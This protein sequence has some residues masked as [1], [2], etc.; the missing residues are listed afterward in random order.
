[1]LLILSVEGP[2]WLPL[3]N[4]SLVGQNEYWGWG[5]SS[6]AVSTPGKG[7][8]EPLGAHGGARGGLWGLDDWD[9]ITGCP[10]ADKPR[11]GGLVGGWARLTRS[12]PDELDLLSDSWIWWSLNGAR[13]GCADFISFAGN[14]V[15]LNFTS[16][17]ISKHWW[18]AYQ[19]WYP[20]DPGSYPTKI[21]SQLLGSSLCLLFLKCAPKLDN[22]R[23]IGVRCSAFFWTE[24]L[25]VFYSLLILLVLYVWSLAL[26]DWPWSG[27]VW[28]WALFSW[29]WTCISEFSPGGWWT[30]N[31][32][33]PNWVCIGKLF[34]YI[35]Q[36][37]FMV[38]HHDRTKYGSIS[39]YIFSSSHQ[40]ALSSHFHS[41]PTWKIM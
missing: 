8:R 13:V 5:G 41:H 20:L 24:V 26:L 9:S 40:P 25:L 14:W 29:T 30:P 10:N 16:W 2:A 35:F 7:L 12:S 22:Q 32:N 18:A 15:S 6:G 21:I 19:N 23:L 33:L 3:I 1:M 36:C 28:V 31:P 37:F 4:C 39:T 27:L 38:S 34:T 11:L 17:E